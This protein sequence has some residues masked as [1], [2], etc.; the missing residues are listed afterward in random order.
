[1]IWQGVLKYICLI[2]LGY[3]SIKK[4]TFF[5]RPERRSPPVKLAGMKM[6]ILDSGGLLTKHS[7]PSVYGAFISSVDSTVST[8]FKVQEGPLRSFGNGPLLT[9]DE[10]DVVLVA[11]SPNDLAG[12][13]TEY[14]ASLAAIAKRIEGGNCKNVLFQGLLKRSN[15]N[16]IPDE[17]A[18]ALALQ[19][20]AAKELGWTLAPWGEAVEKHVESTNLMPPFLPNNSISVYGAY[21]AACLLYRVLDKSSP[22]GLPPQVLDPDHEITGTQYLVKVPSLESNVL[23]AAAMVCSVKKS[24]RLHLK[25]LTATAL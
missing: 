9:R 25:V 12:P 17:Q 23:Q 22:L 3:G 18:A 14:K 13:A 7:I 2:P 21:L 24:P 6:L 4:K 19:R 8:Y 20:T 5:I 10:F 1:M 16:P 11:A 15:I